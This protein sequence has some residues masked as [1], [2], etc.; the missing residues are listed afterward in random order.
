[1]GIQHDK[2]TDSLPETRPETSGTVSCDREVVVYY[3][4]RQEGHFVRG[5]AQPRRKPIQQGNHT[6]GKLESLGESALSPRESSRADTCILFNPMISIVNPSCSFS[7]AAS[8]NDVPF[9]FLLD[10]ESV[11]T[12]LRKSIWDR[13]KQPDDKLEP[14]NQESLVGA[15]GTTLRVYGSACVQWKVDGKEFSH[16]VAVADP[17]IT[18]HIRAGFFERV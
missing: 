6:S 5:C 7:V 3:R 12:I 9:T 15:E 2:N 16:V 13:Y 8:I 17:L 14:W 1:M 10:T 18:S 11:L 4:C